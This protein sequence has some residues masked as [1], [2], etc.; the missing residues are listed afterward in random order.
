MAKLSPMQRTLK[1]LR[2]EGMKYDVA[3][4]FNSFSKR[5]K[6][7]FGIIDV[8]AFKNVPA[9]Y[10]ISQA[11][12]I[13]VGIQ[14]CG[15]DWQPHI[16]KIKASPHGLNWVMAGELWLIGWRELKSGWESRIHK[17]ERGDFLTVPS[18]P[19]KVSKVPDIS[20]L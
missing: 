16:R 10:G 6:D 3:E 14:V 1:W 2:D 17:F 13:I 8:V 11:K 7:L 12:R 9:R 15:K 4:S 19:L 5:R 18:Q 20:A